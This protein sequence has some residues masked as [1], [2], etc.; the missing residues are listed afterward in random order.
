MKRS[1]PKKWAV[2]QVKTKPKEYFGRTQLSRLLAWVEK[3][4][5]RPSLWLKWASFNM[6]DGDGD[7]SSAWWGIFFLWR[8]V[9]LNLSQRESSA[10]FF[11][12]KILFFWRYLQDA[13]TDENQGS[14]AFEEF[15]T[16]YKMIST[17]RDLYLIMISYSN[18]KEVMDLHD[19]ARFL[20]NE[21][22][23]QGKKKCSNQTI[24]LLC[25]SFDLAAECDFYPED[26]NDFHRKITRKKKNSKES[27]NGAEV[28]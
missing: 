12:P 21:Q 28:S 16:F 20:E 6:F 27:L 24:T 26:T 4:T 18:Q 10:Y 1:N 25:R 9:I 15:C 19:L 22:K 2:L 13:D 23:V 8:V 11:A 7:K 5:V 17:R 14:L 3:P